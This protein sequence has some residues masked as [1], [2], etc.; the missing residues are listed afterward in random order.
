MKKL[1]LTLSIFAI[2][3]STSQAQ[4]DGEFYSI[5]RSHSLLQFKVEHIGFSSVTGNFN[6]YSGMI[7]FNPKNLLETSATLIIEA[8]TIDT[9]SARDGNL[10]KH[11]FETEKYPKL[12]FY[13]TATLK[14]N[15]QYFLV[16]N[17]T[18]RDVTR[19]VEIPFKLKSGPIKDQFKHIRIAFTGSLT[20]DR[21]DY[22]IYYRNVEFWD[23]I[24]AK[25]VYIDIETSA[26]IYNSVE[27]VFPF[28]EN[29][30]GRLCF[31]AYQVGGIE[32]ARKK[33][34]EVLA[35]PEN[36]FITMI[37]MRRGATHLAQSGN[38]KG[39]LELL[40]LGISI[41]KDE[42]EPGDLAKFSSHKARHLSLMGEYINSKRFA[43]EALLDDPHNT[44]ALEVLKQVEDK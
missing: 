36:Y 14:K 42:M 3:T 43:E 31:E 32:A 35:D 27:T 8:Q 24:V 11:F 7:Y 1:L 29:S 17:L 10:T 15:K 28:N 16:G 21:M 38:R 12:T 39:A 18:I 25:E 40:D 20:I 37:Q 44:L 41:F 13:S 30:I 6:D 19:Q 34:Q 26:R 5:D 33:S 9:R 4:L 22:G 23:N 2:T